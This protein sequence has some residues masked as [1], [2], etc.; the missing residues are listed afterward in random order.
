MSGKL[1]QRIARWL[2]RRLSVAPRRKHK[3]LPARLHVE[4]LAERVL[5]AVVL[6][7]FD[8]PFVSPYGVLPPEPAGFQGGHGGGFNRLVAG[9]DGNLWY[10]L[11]LSAA[12][13]RM[14]PDGQFTQFE[15]PS[16]NL[17][18]STI[19]SMASGRDG[20]V[21]YVVTGSD[22]GGVRRLALGKITPAG[23][24]TEVPM[25]AQYLDSGAVGDPIRYLWSIQEMVQG[26]D[27]NFWFMDVATNRLGR[28][29]LDGTVT[30][31]GQDLDFTPYREGLNT[32]E[33]TAGP[34]NKLWFTEP[35]QSQVG[36][37]D[38]TTNTVT[39]FD[40]APGEAVLNLTR[41]PNGT[42]W[43]THLS[44]YTTEF[45]ADGSQQRLGFYSSIGAA[46]IARDGNLWMSTQQG[47]ARYQANGERTDYQ[48][49]FETFPSTESLLEGELV[50]LSDGGLWFFYKTRTSP[51]D[52]RQIVRL[53]I[54]APAPVLRTEV[55]PVTARAGELPQDALLARF[56]DLELKPGFEPEHTFLAGTAD[57]GDGSPV[58]RLSVRPGPGIGTYEMV[59][60]HQ[61]TRGG[62]FVIDVTAFTVPSLFEPPAPP[63]K[64]DILT[65]V[66]VPARA[67]ETTS[68]HF[69]VEVYNSILHRDPEDAGRL[70]WMGLLDSGRTREEVTAA[71]QASPEAQQGSID[72]LYRTWLGRAAEPA[73]ID[74]WTRLLASG[75]SISDVQAGILASEEF[76]SRNGGN[77][78]GFLTGLYQAV[79]NRTPETAGMNAWTQAFADGQSRGEVAARVL[80]STEARGRIVEE[81]YQSLLERPS[82]VQGADDWRRYLEQGRSVEELVRALVTSAEFFSKRLGPGDVLLP[83]PGEGCGHPTGLRGV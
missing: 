25:P 22:G 38:V 30:E 46:A 71:I 23:V 66:Q 55:F 69:V 29:A 81:A 51:Y 4:Q 67:S 28:I 21:W 8:I 2:G 47:F 72:D 63:T 39:E 20:N 61:F 62:T 49:Y 36:Y 68:F 48:S 56:T 34:G 12:I 19:I 11:S 5:P 32:A 26:P 40:Y 60:Y 78:S 57:F 76:W 74:A 6:K 70:Y 13:G 52:I 3:P 80:A 58:S 1:S 24:A 35:N 17:L 16:S 37:I 14:T 53:D 77:E 27:G 10:D 83:P 18:G 79:L 65:R 43:A 31:F 59:A 45:T 73:G 44:G 9:S 50:P 82:D 54:D 33:L 64:D 42:L 15:L 41:T 7:P 75:R